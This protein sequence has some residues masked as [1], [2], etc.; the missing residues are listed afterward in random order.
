VLQL[1][2]ETFIDRPRVAIFRTY[3][4]KHADLVEQNDL[5]QAARAGSYKVEAE[6]NCTL[7]LCELR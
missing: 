1:Y 5:E 7:R 3:A 6:T 2:R 4:S